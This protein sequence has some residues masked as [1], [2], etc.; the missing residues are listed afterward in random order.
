MIVFLQFPLVDIRC[1]IDKGNVNR[2]G[3]PN[4]P[5][6][7][8]LDEFV[9]A[10]GQVKPRGRGGLRGW[11]GENE[12]CD[13]SRAIR[14]PSKLPSFIDE[15]TD[16][17][18]N[19]KCSSRHF[20]YDGRTVGKIELVFITIPTEI[21]FSSNS[22]FKLINHILSIPAT[23]VM[24]EYTNI[25]KIQQEKR[26]KK[27]VTKQIFFIGKY[28][29]KLYLF[30]SSSVSSYKVISDKD[31]I[32]PGPPDIFIECGVADRVRM[33]ANSK[34]ALSEDQN[35]FGIELNHWWHKSG[36]KHIRVWRL[37]Y[38][39]NDKR[40]LQ[41]GRTLRLYIQRLHTECECLRIIL[42]CIK[43]GEISPPQ[44]DNIES[45][46]LIDYLNKASKKIL[47][48]SNKTQKKY[49]VDNDNI[50]QIAYD[51]LDKINPGSRDAFL[52]NIKQIKPQISRK[53]EDITNKMMRRDDEIE[54]YTDFYLHIDLNG[55]I[56]ATSEEG[57]REG[58]ISCT[59]PRNIALTMELIKQNQG[60]EEL[61]K[62]LGKNLYELLFCESINIH[63]NQTEAV[64]RK[65][66][67][68]VRIRL[69][70]KPDELAHVPWEFL[71]REEGGYFLS[72]HPKTVL[73]RFFRLP[74]PQNR[75]RRREGPL[76]LLLIIA[77]PSDQPQLNSDS[78]EQ[79]ITKALA[80][81]L[82]EDTLRIRTV[83]QATRRNISDALLAQSPD[84]VQFVGHG[85]YKERRGYLALVNDVTG[86]TWL[87]DDKRFANIFLGADQKLGLVSLA[88]CESAI[89]DS[90]RSFL[91]IAPQ[92]V[93]RGVPAVVAMQYSVLVSTAEIFLEE[94][95]K[96]VAA[97]KPVDWA[98]QWARNQVSLDKGLNNREFATPVLYMRAEDGNIF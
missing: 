78:W 9:R 36:N 80:K 67:R 47:N 13:A 16:R 51:S 6:P 27:S 83:K 44:K 68:K 69:T 88:T 52:D 35:K 55:N 90:P 72:V 12:I 79:I 91:G 8:P 66:N 84:I 32:I 58:Q 23:I 92:I 50:E 28:L 94:F 37:K 53:I 4:W 24:P 1:F 75:V 7:S 93:Q 54:N 39:S 89:S 5:T 97:R 65:S 15:E 41:A 18:I 77:N 86:R 2:L 64:T 31:W 63:F 33:P 17:E 85:I 3:R 73:S 61:L 71:Y 95:Y 14:L 60:D 46:F 25:L 56:L 57:E 11:V 42:R 62:E 43:T 82:E 26:E 34:I 70:V 38:T 74:L 96:A 10:F 87:V 40:N 48:L 45:E 30:S 76:D 81:P 21:S 19:V 98:V 59:I 20:Y 29:A 49:E 22:L